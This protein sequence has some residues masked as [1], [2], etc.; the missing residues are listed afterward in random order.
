MFVGTGALGTPRSDSAPD[1]VAFL[2]I[3]TISTHET[4]LNSWRRLLPIVPV[5]RR[6]RPRGLLEKPEGGNSTSIAR[7]A[8]QDGVSAAA[9]VD[10][11]RTPPLQIKAQQFA[12]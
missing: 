1:T 8:L 6:L 7:S 2:A 10:P 11:N 5:W 4:T 12:R 3:A 9:G